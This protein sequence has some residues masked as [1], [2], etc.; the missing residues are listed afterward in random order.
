[1]GYERPL[2][3]SGHDMPLII[4]APLIFTKSIWLDD[5]LKPYSWDES[6]YTRIMIAGLADFVLLS[7]TYHRLQ[8]T[9]FLFS[10]LLVVSLP[11]RAFLRLILILRSA[12]SSR[13][14]YLFVLL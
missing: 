10:L 14:F 5:T 1:M 7:S 9:R 12:C 2:L 8:R 11:S 6:G 3:R 4:S 13:P